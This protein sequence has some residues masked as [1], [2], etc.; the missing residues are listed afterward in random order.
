[1]WLIR[2]GSGA[3]AA[4]E[5][6]AIVETGQKPGKPSGAR[7]TEP[8]LGS[9]G[10]LGQL[11]SAV[12][13]LQQAGIFVREVEEL[14]VAKIVEHPSTWPLGR[15]EPLQRVTRA[16]PRTFDEVAYRRRKNRR[17]PRGRKD[18]RVAGRHDDRATGF[19]RAA[20]AFDPQHLISER[21]ARAVVQAA[22]TVDESPVEPGAVTRACVFEARGVSWVARRDPGVVPGYARVV[23][24]KRI[25]G[26]APDRH[27][28]EHRHTRPIA[29][30]QLEHT[31]RAGQRRS[32]TRAERGTSLNLAVAVRAKH[33]EAVRPSHHA[34]AV[35]TIAMASHVNGTTF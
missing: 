15:L 26:C 19:A 28:V 32:A 20:L 2:W 3:V 27:P 10:Q 35:P 12:E 34:V 9:L 11:S 24:L 17:G 6:A 23:E 25:A 33:R 13:Q 21:D 14:A 1:L 16:K 31:G 18:E 29:K 30:Y 7:R 22:R 8:L 5:E 4:R